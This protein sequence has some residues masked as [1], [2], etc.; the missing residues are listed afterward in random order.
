MVEPFMVIVGEMSLIVRNE[1]EGLYEETWQKLRALHIDMP[2]FRMP[3]DIVAYDDSELAHRTFAMLDR[4][5]RACS[6]E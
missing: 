1:Y 2:G 6:D 4:L 3:S 5:V